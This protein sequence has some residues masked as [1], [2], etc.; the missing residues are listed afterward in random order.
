MPATTWPLGEL[1]T[2]KSHRSLEQRLVNG[3]SVRERDVFRQ[4]P[5]HFFLTRY[6]QTFRDIAALTGR[7]LRVPIA[8]VGQ[9]L[10]A[11]KVLPIFADHV[12]FSPAPLAP[13]TW[14]SW[15]PWLSD[16]EAQ[17]LKKDFAFSDGD[18]HGFYRRDGMSLT[19][20]HGYPATLAL[21]KPLI[22]KGFA[23]FLPASG[24]R[25]SW[26]RPELGLV[27]PRMTRLML[28]PQD[29][30]QYRVEEL[31]NGLCME[32]VVSLKLGCEHVYNRI[33]FSTLVAPDIPLGPK[34]GARTA[35]LL[36]LKIPFLRGITVD[37]LSRIVADEQEA[38]LRLRTAIDKLIE[39]I[40]NDLDDDREFERVL[41]RLQRQGLEEPLA[42]L[43]QKLDRITKFA[44]YRAA[45]VA[46]GSLALAYFALAVPGLYGT[47]AGALGT[48]SL[49][50][51]INDWLKY[52]EEKSK[53]RD[54]SFYF[55]LRLSEL[56]H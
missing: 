8:N 16:K 1:F 41:A 6:D 20:G 49:V 27:S 30:R 40:P 47:L 56:S 18:N 28:S 54:E 23:S 51:V 25:G 11:A 5:V 43:Q 17:T 52:L 45:G 4:S 12:V 21:L 14:G 24:E 32:H 50:P 39:S 48:V 34:L 46:T 37:D 2:E 29:E 10:A 3:E 9:L 31:L 38:L 36:R 19:W 33:T 44:R 53:L 55:L 15:G 26:D 22:S 42:L 7:K 35:A 13:T